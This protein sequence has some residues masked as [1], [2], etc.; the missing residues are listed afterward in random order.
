MNYL[1]A[2]S[3]VTR[4]EKQCAQICNDILPGYECAC[5]FGYKLAADKHR[6]DDIDE[7]AEGLDNCGPNQK[8][9]SSIFYRK[10][11]KVQTKMMIEK[12]V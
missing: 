1:D 4:P 8:E 11:L 5:N 9:S 7:C 12:S 2:C 3:D 10:F 6:C